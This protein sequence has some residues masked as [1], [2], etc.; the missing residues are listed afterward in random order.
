MII[1][2]HRNL[3]KG[4]VHQIFAQLREF[5]VTFTHS[6]QTNKTFLQEEVAVVHLHHFKQKAVHVTNFNRA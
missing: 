5:D 4:V 3:C 6:T 2:Y 1:T